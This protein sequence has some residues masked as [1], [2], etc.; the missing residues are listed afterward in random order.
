MTQEVIVYMILGIVFFYMVYT[1]IK[2]PKKSKKPPVCDGCSGCDLKND[3]SCSL[4]VGR[5]KG[6]KEL[7]DL[8]DL[9]D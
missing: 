9:G 8:R 4:P 5:T 1:L 2:R 6:L 7:R 3:L